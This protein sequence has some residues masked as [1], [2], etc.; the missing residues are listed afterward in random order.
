MVEGMDKNLNKPVEDKSSE[1]TSPEPVATKRK[2]LKN[3]KWFWA[4]VVVILL[5][6]AGIVYYIV[7]I[8]LTPK[9]VEK[10]DNLSAAT[11]FA[12]PKSLVEKVKPDMRGAA[13]DVTTY[14]GLGGH[15]TDGYSV[16]S[17]PSYRVDGRKFS[18]LPMASFGTGY[19]G[20]QK[21]NEKNYANLEKFFSDNKFALVSS[22]ENESGLISWADGDI[23]YIQYSTYESRNLLCSIWYADAS[24]T[25][26]NSYISSVGCGDKA[27]YTKAAEVLQ[28]YY[29]AYTAGED[30]PS[31]DI[32]LGNPITGNSNT[33]GYKVAVV[34][35]EDSVELDEQFKGFYY[36]KPGDSKWTYF[37]G[38]PGWLD[39][40]DF[41]T[42]YAK[43]AFDGFECYD[44]ATDSI[45]NVGTSKKA[46]VLK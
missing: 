43:K 17:V 34:Y 33:A 6:L 32:V 8:A 36:K 27:S 44:E 26:L 37:Y 29:D 38:A 35:Q 46:P 23:N 40:P 24:G 45:K 39:C 18:N 31:N 15:T 11:H 4:G 7:S 21:Q 19:K 3:N 16:Y 9:T 41:N 1:T 22:G 12:S 28:Q 10:N 20:D 25:D 5:I 2:S 42:D 30:K 13:L 14:D